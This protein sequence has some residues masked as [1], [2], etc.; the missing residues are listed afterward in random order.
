MNCF[1]MFWK[2]KQKLMGSGK[3]TSTCVLF[4]PVAII[5]ASTYYSKYYFLTGSL[6]FKGCLWWADYS[7]P[8][9]HTAEV[10]QEQAG[11]LRSLYPS[12]AE[13]KGPK[14][15]MALVLERLWATL[16]ECE[17]RDEMSIVMLQEWSKF[18]NTVTASQN[19]FVRSI[20]ESIFSSFIA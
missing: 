12:V 16:H 13:I 11:W 15:H 17:N 6:L 1:R 3:M 20:V 19:K 2:S 5:V 9:H 18:Q 8:S 14:Q 4:S 7:W 10:S